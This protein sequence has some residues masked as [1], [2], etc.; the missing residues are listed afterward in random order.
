[1]L[2]QGLVLFQR[3]GREWGVQVTEHAVTHGEADTVAKKPRRRTVRTRPANAIRAVS[4][5]YW[6][7]L[8]LIAAGDET[9]LIRSSCRLQA[10]VKA[11]PTL[12][13]FEPVEFESIEKSVDDANQ[14]GVENKGEAVDDQPGIVVPDTAGTIGRTTSHICGIWSHYC[15]DPDREQR[16]PAYQ[17]AMLDSLDSLASMTWGSL[18]PHAADLVDSNTYKSASPDSTTQFIA[19]AL[20]IAQE[21]SPTKTARLGKPRGGQSS[22]LLRGGVGALP[23][24]KDSQKTPVRPFMVFLAIVTLGVQLAPLFHSRIGSPKQGKV[25]QVF[26]FPL[27]LPLDG[28][29]KAKGKL[30][31]A[32][33]TWM[34]PSMSLPSS[35]RSRRHAARSIRPPSF[36][37]RP[38]RRCSSNLAVFRVK[39]RCSSRLRTT[40]SRRGTSS[41]GSSVRRRSWRQLAPVRSLTTMTSTTTATTTATPTMIV[42][43]ETTVTMTPLCQTTMT[44]TPLCQTDIPAE[45]SAPTTQDTGQSLQLFYV[46]SFHTL[47]SGPGFPYGI[48]LPRVY[49]PSLTSV[50]Q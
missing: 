35:Q 13:D 6:T 38:A 43:T 49:S 20:Q 5:W 22:L 2:P 42:W 23:N 31:P 24:P 8:G 4:W 27:L 39:S 9:A 3:T 17:E 50:T 32:D 1:M 7:V 33:A 29:V 48:F 12:K 14:V 45:G 16:K 18:L 41:S 15:A 37:L 26:A 11:I 10:I 46:H 21:L 44:T 25:D 28:V 34:W 36:R 40:S 19:D 30:A 47:V